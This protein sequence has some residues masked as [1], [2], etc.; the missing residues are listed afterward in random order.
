[1]RRHSVIARLGPADKAAINLVE[2]GSVQTIIRFIVADKRLDFGIGQLIDQLTKRDVLA[3]ENGIDLAILAALVTAADTRISRAT[4][5]QDSWTREIDLY[6]PVHEPDRWKAIVPL[7][8]RTLRFLTGDHWRLL[9][10]ARHT[11]YKTLAPTKK[12]LVDATFDSI[13]LF[14]GGLDSFIGAIDLMAAKKNALFVSHYWDNST[15]SQKLCA[16][17][18]GAVYG[19]MS[20]RHVRTR[21]GFR[22]ALVKG[23]KEETTTRGRS[24]LFFALAAL[25]ASGITVPAIYI[26]ENGLISLNVPLDPLRLGA[27]ST[28]T[29]HPFYLARWQEILEGLGVSGS[30]QNPYRFQ[31]K[32]EMLRRCANQELVKQY[33]AET[34]SCSSI[35]KGRWKKLPKGH[36]GHCTPCLIRRAAFHCAFAD[37]KT[38]YSIPDLGAKTFTGSSAQSEHIRS[39]RLMATRLSAEKDIE[40]IL[41]HK[42]GPLS[43]YTI[44]E[45]ADYS[46]V[47]RRGIEEVNEVIKG[48]VIKT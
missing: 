5:S 11:T 29:T 47:F 42:P 40:S 33:G 43:D 39:F 2:S 10:R 46:G 4:E 34:I 1:M 6:L 13:C 14:S 19:D 15:S 38:A 36:C 35:G 44:Q 18:I 20:T 17:R 3:S 45:I 25:A 28:R 21:V 32:G 16:S 22:T 8:E 31:T 12:S 9:I 37:D 27:W 7:I 30:L 24:F 41:V 26:P 23:S 48:V